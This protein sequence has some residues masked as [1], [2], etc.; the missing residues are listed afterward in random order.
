[1]Q[2]VRPLMGYAPLEER[3]FAL[4]ARLRRLRFWRRRRLFFA[5]SQFLFRLAEGLRNRNMLAIGN[6]GEIMQSKI[7][8]KKY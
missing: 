2:K 7:P 8:A 6:H 1:M 3:H 5:P 4:G